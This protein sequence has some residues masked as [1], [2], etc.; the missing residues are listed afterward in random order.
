M[1]NTS[2]F[3]VVL[4]ATMSLLACGGSSSESQTDAQA[5]RARRVTSFYQMSAISQ[6][7]ALD[8]D[9]QR[10]INFSAMPDNSALDC[11]HVNGAIRC[12]S[13]YAWVCPDGWTPC[14][15]AGSKTCCERSA[16][17]VPPTEVSQELSQGL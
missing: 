7:A 8:E 5:L 3:G 9:L 1:K 11:T 6:I 12:V 15:Q 14:S 13:D 2:V 16:D 17:V 4:L 10:N